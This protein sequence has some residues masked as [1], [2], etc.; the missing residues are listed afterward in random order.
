MSFLVALLLVLP[1]AFPF[2]LYLVC[3]L[4]DSLIISFTL[5]AFFDPL[6]RTISLVTLLA[7][8]Q[9]LEFLSLS[10]PPSNCR[11]PKRFLLL[12]IQKTIRF[13]LFLLLYSRAYANFLICLVRIF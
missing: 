9:L 11:L 5:L 1:V 7:S 10:K 3:C 2:L 13:L 8:G 12:L 4:S 6:D